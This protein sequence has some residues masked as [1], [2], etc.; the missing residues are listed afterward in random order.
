LK[1]VVA[2]SLV[3]ILVGALVGV[4]FWALSAKD[5]AGER[6]DAARAR[7]QELSESLVASRRE[8]DDVSG[9]LQKKDENLKHQRGR[10]EDLQNGKS[11]LRIS[12]A[13][14]S[15]L[16]SVMIPDGAHLRSTHV[17]GGRH[18]NLVVTSW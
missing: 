14:L 7:T 13:R 6:S 15:G 1:R 16:R 10:I 18:P 5:R 3:V 9:S 12:L 2:V 17:A 4:S 8:T 11:G